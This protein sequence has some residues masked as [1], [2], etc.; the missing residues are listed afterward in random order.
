MELRKRP[1]LGMSRAIAVIR[2]IFWFYGTVVLLGVWVGCG[3]GIFL[4]VRDS[5]YYRFGAGIVLL[6][7][8][9]L[10]IRW[11][12]RRLSPFKKVAG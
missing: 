1:W 4:A 6:A 9:H 8:L 5:N 10:V 11:P 7:M 3:A 12:L 2:T